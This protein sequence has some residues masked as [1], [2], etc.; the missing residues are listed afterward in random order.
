MPETWGRIENGLIIPNTN[1]WV[2]GPMLLS[3]TQAHMFLYYRL[4]TEKWV[5][6]PRSSAFAATWYC[7]AMLTVGVRWRETYHA[8]D[9]NVGS[10]GIF[11]ASPPRNGFIR[12]GILTWI[13]PTL[14]EFV[15]RARESSG[16]QDGTKYEM[17]A[18]P[19]H[20]DRAMV[21][22]QK[23]QKSASC[24]YYGDLFS[25]LVDLW[26]KENSAFSHGTVNTYW[27]IWHFS[28][29][30]A[31]PDATF[32]RRGIRV[33]DEISCLHQ[34]RRYWNDTGDIEK[35]CVILGEARQ[36]G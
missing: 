7:R 22:H 12:L 13:R 1:Q 30:Y 25:D 5:L 14:G 6:P 16:W 36:C 23:P 33:S 8:N 18:M 10:K 17:E 24:F 2:E 26:K 28:L 35:M 19:N 4:Y 20:G 15:P 9:H 32:N 29:P 27:D 34:S 31:T 3:D 21:P 11:R